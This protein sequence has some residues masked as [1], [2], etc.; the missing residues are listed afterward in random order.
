MNKHTGQSFEEFCTEEGLSPMSLRVINT[1]YVS[2]CGNH[3]CLV[4]DDYYGTSWGQSIDSRARL[5][6]I[7]KNWIKLDRWIDWLRS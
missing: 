6:Y 2:P 5:C 7:R 4:E 3:I 1:L